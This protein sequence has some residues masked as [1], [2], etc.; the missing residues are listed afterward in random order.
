MR[1]ISRLGRAFT[2]AALLPA[3][4]AAQQSSAPI[5][6]SWFWGAGGGRVSFPTY[7]HRVDAP[8]ITADWLIT[9]QRWALQ[10]YGSQAYFTDSST[11]TDPNSSG[12][13]KVEITDLRRIG[14][15]GIVF[16][17][18]WTWFR[19][20]AGVGYSFNFVKQATPIGSFFNSAAA[21]DSAQTRVNDA[22]AMSKATFS[23]GFMVTWH[24]FA[25]YAQYTV[26]PTK[27]TGDWLL[28]GDG[29][30]SIWEVGLRYNF[31]PSVER[32]K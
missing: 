7:F 2:L 31:G 21:R 14:F 28:N 9:R 32:V 18:N 10:I 6:N 19:P 11:V 12:L 23:G 13:R 16:L 8:A 22:K 20:Y 3:A 24:R 29:A 15:Q 26:M 1:T 30:T 25:P 5:E 27:G 4:A 17:P